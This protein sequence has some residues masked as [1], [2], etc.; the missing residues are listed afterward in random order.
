[1]IDSNEVFIV[2]GRNQKVKS[3]VSD[4][5]RSFRLSPII[6]NQ[7]AN[8]GMTVIEKFEK[9]ANVGY[10]VVLMTDD[11]L[12][13]EKSEADLKP[14][15]RQNVVLELGY[16]IAKSRGKICI[17]YSAGVEL[18]SDLG[19]IIYE[20]IDDDGIWKSAL[21][22]EL[23]KA[24]FDNIFL[25][26]NIS[27]RTLKLNDNLKPFTDCRLTVLDFD[28]SE[29]SW[30][31]EG[32]FGRTYVDIIFDSHGEQISSIEYIYSDFGNFTF[33]AHCFCHDT[34]NNENKWRWIQFQNKS[35][36]IAKA[37]GQLEKQYPVKSVAESGDRKR[38][39]VSVGSAFQELWGDEGLIFTG[40]E[41]M[42]VRGSGKLFEIIL[43]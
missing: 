9:Y 37:P 32:D 13:K 5:L 2:H 12:G 35:I 10:A 11:D 26:M 21:E 25:K 40:V 33:Y 3:E 15:A 38:V 43:R 7:E 14:R 28:G 16:F 19:G 22:R 42:R 24:G 27:D 17:L 30:S 23:R 8:E 1:M 41:F 39:K 6:L 18:P 34:K 36:A 31:I 29:P 20:M 4:F